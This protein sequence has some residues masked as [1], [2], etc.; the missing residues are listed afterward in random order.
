MR[1]DNEKDNN[2]VFSHDL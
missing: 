1:I 2:T